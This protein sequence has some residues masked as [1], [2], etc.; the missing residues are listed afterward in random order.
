MRQ[1]RFF[2]ANTQIHNNIYEHVYSDRKDA[3]LFWKTEQLYYV[4]SESKYES[5]KFPFKD[6]E[7]NFDASEIQRMKTNEK[8][9]VVFRL[10]RVDHDEKEIIFKVSYP[11]KTA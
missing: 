5:M 8:K 1:E 11:L 7:V 9:S 4:K 2:F 3:T 6:W 10:V